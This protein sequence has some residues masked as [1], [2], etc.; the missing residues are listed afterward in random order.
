MRSTVRHAALEILRKVQAQRLDLANAQAQIRPKLIDERDRTLV[1]EIVV[2][3]LRWRAKLDFII[4]KASSRSL[5]RIDVDLLDL[6]RLSAYQLLYLDRVPAYAV[7]YEAVSLAPELGKKS[8]A[9][10]INAVLR[11]IARE[12]A[13]QQLPARPINAQQTDRSDVLDYLSITQSHPRWLMERWCDRYG[14]DATIKWTVFNNAV[15]PISL[16][17]NTLKCS[18]SRLTEELLACAVETRPSTWSPHTLVVTRGNP[19][20]TPLAAQG[21]FWLQDEASQIIGELVTAQPGSQI[22]DVCAAPGGKALIAAM[23]M[24]DRGLVVAADVRP[25]RT[26]LL[27]SK[28][29]EYRTQSTKVVRLDGRTLPF[30]PVMQW[31]V[32]DAP[33]SGLGTLRRDPDIRWKRNVKDLAQFATLQTQLLQEAT[34]VIEPGGRILYS[35]CSSEPEENEHVVRQFLE[36][37]PRFVIE[38]PMNPQ[39][40]PLIDEDGFVRT[41][42]HRDGLEAFFAATLKN[43]TA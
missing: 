16:R 26:K 11:T 6:L 25:A 5:N 10:F 18:T 22:L 17:I 3:T 8:A 1:H 30:P 14:A 37:N 2:G 23:H 41:L 31:V 32:V 36:R 39:I 38:R 35:T 7:V 27:A 43:E 28:F 21:L 29:K 20:D 40:D 15:A 13:S 19:Q 34:R 12:T 9:P 24:K 4:Q 33:C 42:P